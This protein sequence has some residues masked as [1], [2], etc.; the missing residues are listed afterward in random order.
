MTVTT[1]R[2]RRVHV[3]A[4]DGLVEQVDERVGRRRRSEPMSGAVQERLGRLRRAE[5]FD[6]VVR[7][8]R[9]G[10]IPEWEMVESTQAWVRT[11]RGDRE[12]RKE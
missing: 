2:R 9:D 6:R 7:S 1:E 12:G 11:L 8:S 10:G 3:V 4:L 5:A